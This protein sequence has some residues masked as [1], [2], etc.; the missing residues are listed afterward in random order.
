LARTRWQ[1]PR[2]RGIVL[3]ATSSIGVA[4]RTNAAI[5]RPTTRIQRLTERAITFALAEPNEHL[6]V[7]QLAFLARGDRTLYVRW[8]AIGFLARTRYPDQP[9]A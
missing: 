8:R 3:S 1:G 6:A 4:D 2:Q 5:V 7:T 9:P